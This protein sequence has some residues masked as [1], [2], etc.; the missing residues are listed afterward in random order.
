M[1]IRILVTAALLAA[2]TAC[3]GS[4]KAEPKASPTPTPSASTTEPAKDVLDVAPGRIGK[5][6]AGMTADEANA[7]GYFDPFVPQGCEIDP[8]LQW[9]KEYAEKFGKLVMDGKTIASM[10]IIDNTT[11][12]DKGIGLDS[13]YAEAKKAYAEK[14]TVGREGGSAIYVTD[15]DYWLGIYFGNDDPGMI[16]D[17]ATVTYMEV[18]KGFKPYLMPDGC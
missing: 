5:V 2:L 11:K 13:T 1:K 14:I 9:K 10:S 7:T 17:T 8:P 4:G 6:K 3:G 12:T 16:K 18:S 15:G